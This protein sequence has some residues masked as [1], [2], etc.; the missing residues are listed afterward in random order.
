MPAAKWPKVLPPLTPEQQR[1]SDQFMKLWH[2]ELAGRP[3]YGL[4]ESFNHNYPVRHS[5]AGFRTTLEIGAGLG[6]HLDYEKLTPEQEQNYYCNEF[7]ENMAAEIRRRHPRVRTILGD[8]QE[9]LDFP[10]GYFDRYIA[11]HVLEHLPNLP[12]AIR[13]AYRLLNRQ[14]GRLLVVIPT[15]GSL[16]YSL[17]RKVSAQRVWN[18]HFDAPYSE[19]YTREHINLPH[20]ILAELDPYFTIASRRYFPLPFLPLVACNLVIGLTLLPR[21]APLPS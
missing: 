2:E 7:R 14:T 11:V 16:A 13:E 9:R 1:R 3:R 19:F 21:P 4:I 20:E 18:R 5:A 6:E 10:D 12:A 17:A 8:C 15:E